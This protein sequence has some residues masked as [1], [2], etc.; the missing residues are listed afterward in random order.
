[1]ES[2][3]GL[4]AA[5]LTTAAYVPQAYKTIK[6]RSTGDLSMITFSTLFIGVIMWLIYGILIGDIP[7]ILANIVT[8]GLTGII[9]YMKL[10]E[11]K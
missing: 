1:M 7:L 11:K 4:L 6:T 5:I 9:F 2:F 10:I 8:S 3:I